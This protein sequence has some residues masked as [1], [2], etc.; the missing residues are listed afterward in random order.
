MFCLSISYKNT[1]YNIREK[2]SFSKDTQ[3][4]ILACLKSEGIFQCVILCTCNRTEIY[5]CG[6]EEK[7]VKILSEYSGLSEE[8]LC[9]YLRSY[10]NDKAILH[11]FR[12]ACGIESMVIGED[13]ILGQTKNAYLFAKSCGTVDYEINVVFQ[14]AFSC[15]KKIKT[16]TSISNVSVSTATLAAN[17]AAKFSRQVNVLL[18]GATGSIGSVILK[19]LTSHKNISVTA[20]IRSHNSAIKFSAI[21]NINTI[22]YAD[23]YNYTDTADCIISATSGPHYTITLKDLKNHLSTQKPRLFIDMAVPRDIDRNIT[24]LSQVN[25]IDI[26]HFEQLAKE[27]NALR[28]DSVDIAKDIINSEMDKLKKEL[29]F[30]DFIPYIQKSASQIN[31]KLI[32]KLKAE[33]DFH[34]FSKVLESLKTL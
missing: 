5:F 28:L 17:E 16:D 24:K 26:D 33:L 23:R 7:V 22:D 30:H 27:N 8:N 12:V 11:L 19:D 32:Y 4:K 25:L 29:A 3:G 13:E 14:W 15:S 1:P 20:T 34:S 31:E 2:L 9:P 18:I 6:N 21:D 10:Q